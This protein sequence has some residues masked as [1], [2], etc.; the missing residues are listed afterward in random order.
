MFTQTEINSLT[1]RIT[2]QF[3]PSKI[4]LFGS[5]AFGTPTSDSDLDLCIVTNLEGKRKLDIIRAVRR[6]IT[7]VLHGALDILVYG[8][9]EFAQRSALQNTLEHKI[10]KE[11]KLLHG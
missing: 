11:G 3:S 2:S 7:A 8:D 10:A 9:E 5:Y 6:E 1:N 4:F